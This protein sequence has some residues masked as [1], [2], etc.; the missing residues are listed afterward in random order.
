MSD[1]TFLSSPSW[2]LVC[3]GVM[4]GV[5]WGAGLKGKREPEGAGPLS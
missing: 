3:G 4:L 5:A 1:F 2:E